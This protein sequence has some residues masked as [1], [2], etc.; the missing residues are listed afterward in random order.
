[1]P[2][3]QLE[4]L[5]QPLR[6]YVTPMASPKRLFEQRHRRAP[7]NPF[8]PF[9]ICPCPVRR[10][11]LCNGPRGLL[12]GFTTMDRLDYTSLSTIPIS[13]ATCSLGN[14]SNPP[15]LLER[16]HAISAAGLSAV[17]LSFPDILSYAQTLRGHD[18]EP[19][20]YQALC[21]VAAE[22]RHECSKRNLSMVDTAFCQLRRLA[23]GLPRSR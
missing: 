7:V 4:T 23:R 18:V 12:D 16:L 19:S 1:M 6:D 21:E 2:S 20:D 22:I 9:D 15:P 14:T 10:F 3:W 13:Y 17:E 8:A 11:Y 5:H